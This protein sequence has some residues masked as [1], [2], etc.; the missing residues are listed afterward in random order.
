MLEDYY[1]LRDPM[2]SGNRQ[3]DTGV[4]LNAPTY[5]DNV[6]ELERLLNA[7]RDNRAAP[8]ELLHA[9][10]KV[11]VRQMWWHIK[12]YYIDARVVLIHPAKPPRP[13]KHHRLQV[14]DEGRPLPIRVTRRKHE[15]RQ[16]IAEHG[17]TWILTHW[18]LRHEP[19]Y[20]T[21]RSHP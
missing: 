3:G 2:T 20:P 21:I 5:D 1:E 8:L 14:D 6:K 18:D 19:M 7:M 4:R 11:S 17:I 15:A 10:E 16:D 12:A 9:R 13:R